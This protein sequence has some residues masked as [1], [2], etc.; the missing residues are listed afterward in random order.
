MFAGT[1][2]I[3]QAGLSA[4]NWSNAGRYVDS[5]EAAGLPAAGAAVRL[6]AETTGELPCIVREDND[7]ERDRLPNSPQWHLLHN[8]PNQEQTPFDFYSSIVAGLQGDGNSYLLK[9]KARGQ[10]VELVP[11]QP[12]AV[13]PFFKEG[14]M[15]YRVYQDGKSTVL[16]RADLIHIPGILFGHPFI[17]VSPISR[18]R[19][20]LGGALAAEEFGN[21]FFTNG[22]S[23]GGVVEVPDTLTKEQKEELMEGWNAGHKGVS[24][25]HK[26]GLLTN[27]AKYQSIGVSMQDA[28]Y[29]E[30]QRFSVQQIARIFRVPSSMIGDDSAQKTSNT[31]PEVANQAFLQFSL[32]PWL[33]RI[34]Q[35]LWKDSDLFP[36][37]SIKPA[38]V[39]EAILR[40]DITSR[41]Q[42]YLWAKQAGWL[43]ANEIRG[44]ED[45]PP[46]EGGDELQQTPVGGAP[47]P[48]QPT[49]APGGP[50]EPEPTEA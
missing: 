17:G 42:A 16:T 9:L 43:T 29:V 5:A 6:L 46:I 4:G 15:Q 37:K 28:A 33:T 40:A 19:N 8:E 2:R 48:G 31:H 32:Q 23:A 49:P 20:S 50:P 36:D 25:A 14:K 34:E 13:Y 7:D 27:G 21:R 12:G 11:F 39:V 30:S 3:P 44:K 47:N 45:M 1:D 38:F 10:V 35:A 22:G 24:N 18:H 41:Y 26:T